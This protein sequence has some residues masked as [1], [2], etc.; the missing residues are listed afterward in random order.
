MYYYYHTMAKALSAYGAKTLVLKDGK[1][2]NWRRDLTKRLLDAQSPEGFWVN[3]NNRWWE[4]DPVLVT[5]YAVLTL[6][7][8]WRGL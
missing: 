3:K 7:I 2:I 5:S 6:E 1:E 4:R 8:L